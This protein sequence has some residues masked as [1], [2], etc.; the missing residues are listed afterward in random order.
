MLNEILPMTGVNLRT[1]GIK[2]DRSTNWATTTSLVAE[3]FIEHSNLLSH[4]FKV[5]KCLLNVD[6]NASKSLKGNACK[7]FTII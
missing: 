6:K 1:S 2:S 3:L 4:I 7:M 5:K